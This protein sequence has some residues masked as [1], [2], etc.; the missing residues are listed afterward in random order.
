MPTLREIADLLGCAVSGGAD[1]A[2]TGVA[3]LKEATDKEMSYVGADAFVRE[4]ATC[5]A[6]A[7]IAQENVKIPET[8]TRPTFRV[9]DAELAVGKVLQL[10]APPVPRPPAGIDPMARVESSAVLGADVAIGPFV[11]IGQRVRIGA[12]SVIH[13]GACIGDDTTLGEKC[14]IYQSVVIRERITI[15]DRVILNAGCVIG[16]D[17]FGYRWDG[18]QHVKIPQIGVVIIEDDV[19]IGSNACIDRAKFS[20]TRVG[21]GTKIDNLVQVGHN[22]QIGPH[23]ILAGQ[24]G[25]AGTANLGMG[26]VLGGQS[27]VRDH[28]SVGAGAMIAGTSGVAEDVPPGQIYSGTP[29]LPHRQSLREQK[30]LRRLP[31]LAVQLRALLDEVAE[32]K[33]KFGELK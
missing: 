22:V 31:D 12:G 17:G 33:K 28:V 11:Y 29:A 26:A 23:C 9:K 8:W 25:I 19:E 16:T 1:L 13:A 15:G 5:K 3:A 10:F 7:L 2:I 30:A 21:R 6:A 14:E 18:R 32:L 4:L 20:T 24:V 27:S